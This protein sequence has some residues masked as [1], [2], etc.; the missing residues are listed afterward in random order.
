MNLVDR[1]LKAKVV[2]ETIKNEI[3]ESMLLSK[4]HESSSMIYSYDDCRDKKIMHRIDKAMVYHLHGNW[5]KKFFNFKDMKEIVHISFNEN[6]FYYIIA[7]SYNLVAYQY[8]QNRIRV[9]GPLLYFNRTVSG[10]IRLI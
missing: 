9:S 4:K 2:V 1:I 8:N 3:K 7:I 6:K 5:I 10:D